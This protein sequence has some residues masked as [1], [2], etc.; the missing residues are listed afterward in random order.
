[1][2]WHAIAICGYDDAAG[3]LQFKNSWGPMWG[4][5]GFGTIPYDYVERFSRIQ[6]AGWVGPPPG[7][8]NTL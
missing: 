5:T 6:I 8:V 7:L 3:R 1:M 2:G 4:D